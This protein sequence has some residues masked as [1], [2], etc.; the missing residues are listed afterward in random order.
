M[1]VCCKRE[2][3]D[4]NKK[5]NLPQFLLVDSTNQMSSEFHNYNNLYIEISKSEQSKASTYTHLKRLVI[6]DASRWNMSLNMQNNN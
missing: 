3:T 2:Y 1:F 6:L 4:K 5:L